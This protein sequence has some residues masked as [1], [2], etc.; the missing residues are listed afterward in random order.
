MKDSS[1]NSKLQRKYLFISLM[2][3]IASWQI[4]AVIVDKPIIIPTLV[5]TLNAFFEIVST[6]WFLVAVY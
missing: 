2:I 1:Y 5:E 6:D 4:I 3:L